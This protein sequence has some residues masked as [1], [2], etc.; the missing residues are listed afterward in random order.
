M[1]ETEEHFLE[2]RHNLS[3]RMGRNIQ[4]GK[5][6][7]G[8]IFCPKSGEDELNEALQKVLD[9]CK[10]TKDQI[11][12]VT[13]D[14]TAESANSVVEVNRGRDIYARAFAAVLFVI[15][16][17]A[18]PQFLGHAPDYMSYNDITCAFPESSPKEAPTTPIGREYCAYIA[19]LKES[20]PQ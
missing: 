14:G 2:N 13:F 1:T 6:F 5:P 17:E 3:T 7:T 10:I 16:P 19:E 20:L 4:K 18:R 9:L 11:L 8:V 15:R 12:R